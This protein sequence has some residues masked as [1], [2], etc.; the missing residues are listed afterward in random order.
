MFA[1]KRQLAR[2]ARRE[3]SSASAVSRSYWTAHCAYLHAGLPTRPVQDD[4]LQG[5][6]TVS[7]AA[8]AASK[9]GDVAQLV[10]R[11]LALAVERETSLQQQ[12]LAMQIKV[13]QL[14]VFD[15]QAK[16]VQVCLAG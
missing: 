1:A 7:G 12:A 14:S 15:Q 9:A 4:W 10:E 8:A 11:R 6:H 13:A 5:P 3:S 2:F 16:A